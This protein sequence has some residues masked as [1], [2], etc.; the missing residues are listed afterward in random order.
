MKALIAIGVAIL[1]LWSA[2][3]GE[4]KPASFIASADASRPVMVPE[5]FVTSK[6][7][8]GRY[9]LDNVHSKGKVNCVFLF[10]GPGNAEV[11]SEEP[12]WK[13]VADE[14]AARK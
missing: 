4:W 3:A 7:G 12:E 11:K 8:K 13:A 1:G 10:F 9:R 14:V 5:G 2:H 6:I